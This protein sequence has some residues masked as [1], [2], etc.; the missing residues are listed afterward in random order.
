M[1]LD[2]VNWDNIPAPIVAQDIFKT[3]V[4]AESKP[5]IKDTSNY[6]PWEL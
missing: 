6:L 1:I 5:V 2:P 3:P 4:V